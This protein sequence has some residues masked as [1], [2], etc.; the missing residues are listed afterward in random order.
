MAEKPHSL[1]QVL[2]P[3]YK[4]LTNKYLLVLVIAGVWM[5][6][7]DRYNWQAHQKVEARIVELS[8]DRT[9][10]EQAIEKLDYERTLLYSDLE[11]MERFAREQHYMKR[12][13][14][15]VYVS[16]VE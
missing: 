7:F 6:F 8:A 2:E 1:T 11:E 12:P 10:Y 14:E 13:N 5:M 4:F 9:H 15:D 16:V 3:V